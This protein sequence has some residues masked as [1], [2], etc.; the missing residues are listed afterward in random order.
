MFKSCFSFPK[1][2]RITEGKKEEIKGVNFKSLDFY[3]KCI[4]LI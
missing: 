4:P 1:L 2:A 3:P